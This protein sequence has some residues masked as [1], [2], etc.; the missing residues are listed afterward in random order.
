[1]QAL[2]FLKMLM[3][4]RRINRFS[5]FIL[6]LNTSLWASFAYFIQQKNKALPQPGS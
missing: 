5:S 2:S 3:V 4:V 6:Y 1:M